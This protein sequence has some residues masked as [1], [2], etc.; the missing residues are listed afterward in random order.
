MTGLDFVFFNVNT[1]VNIVHHQAFTNQDRVFV[2]VAFPRH[3]GDE[4]ILTE[5]QFSPFSGR[6][7]GEDLPRYDGLILIHQGPLIEA[8]V[9]VGALI[10][11]DFVFHF[12]GES[13]GSGFF[14][15]VAPVDPNPDALGIH[16]A[17]GAVV[18]RNHHH[19]RVT[20]GLGFEAR[21]HQGPFGAQQGHSLPLHVG[22]HQGAVSVVMFEE[23]NQRGC[24]GD[25]LHRGD[26]DIVH[27]F[28]DGGGEFLPITDGDAIAQNFPIIIGGHIPR[29]HLQI[30]FLVSG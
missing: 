5:G 18:T 4:N 1:G 21:P 28:G 19:P 14:F 17:D 24:H 8:G 22:A 20:G 7:I 29:C 15:F 30:I 10:F 12:I 23:G 3:I 27:L 26:G 11:L 25:N 6:A 2:V 16:I 9:L 13:L